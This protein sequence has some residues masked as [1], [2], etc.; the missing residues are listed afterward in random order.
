[1]AEKRYYERLYAVNILIPADP[2]APFNIVAG[3]MNSG[4]VTIQNYPF[5]IK[6]VSHAI[7]GYN[8][9]VAPPALGAVTQD[10]AYRIR[11]RTNERNYMNEALQAIGAFGGGQFSQPIDLSAP[12][13]MA[14]KETIQ[15]DLINDTL[16]QNQGGLTVQVIF[17]GVEPW[18]VVP[19]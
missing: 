6:R 7:V 8:G 13:E 12:I 11:F 4:S 9:L 10:G 14:P 18:N 16:R 19:G 1:M 5:L 17:S 3:A 2:V 15:V